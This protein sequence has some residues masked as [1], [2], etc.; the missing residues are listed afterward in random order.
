MTIHGLSY[1][2]S[3]PR[4]TDGNLIILYANHTKNDETEALPN[5]VRERVKVCVDLY[6]IINTSK[7]DKKSTLISIIADERSG[8]DI[9]KMLME[10][11]VD[12][13][14][15]LLNASPRNVQQTFDYILEFIQK[16]ANPPYIYFVASIWQKDIFDSVALSKMKDY[17]IRFEGAP[18]HRTGDDIAKEKALNMP[19]KGMEY[20]KD[21][22]KNKAVDMVINHIFPDE[23]KR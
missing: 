18:D 6:R 22:L 20:Y 12:E 14:L 11:G 13:N 23:K 9:K 8:Q 3:R 21:K 1:W 5:H 17:Q 19:T 15:V 7:P 2:M 16:R 10:S 4:F